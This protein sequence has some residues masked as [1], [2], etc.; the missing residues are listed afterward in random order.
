MILW[1]LAQAMKRRRDT[2]KLTTE[3]RERRNLARFRDL[4][5]FAQTTSPW[6]R[7]VIEQNHIDPL[8]CRPEHFPVLTAA[9][10]KDHFDEIVTDRAITRH[11]LESFIEQSR[12]PKDLYLGRYHVV[13]SS[14]SSGI[15]GTY[16]HTTDEIINGM[17]YGALHRNIKPRTRTT[18][19]GRLD[20]HDMGNAV[21]GLMDD[22]PQRLLFNTRNFDITAPWAQIIDGLNKHQPKIISAYKHYLMTLAE[23]A[24]AGR[25]RIQPSLLESGGEPLFPQEREILRSTFGCEIAN[26][27]G[28]T[29]INLMGVA[30]NDWEGIYLFEDDLIFEIGS[31]STCVTNLYNRTLPL[32]RYR[33]DDILM[34]IDVPNPRL[35][36]RAVSEKIGRSQEIIT[37]E[38]GVGDEHRFHTIWL[39]DGVDFTGVKR[40]QYEKKDF[41]TLSVRVAL[42]DQPELHKLCGMTSNN[43]K[44]EQLRRSFRQHLDD[45]GL[46]CVKLEISEVD[47]DQTQPEDRIVRDGRKER[48]VLPPSTQV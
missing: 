25:L 18:F 19:L 28:S 16:L 5:A 7:R 9:M 21:M 11:G 13:Q 48:L 43:E 2:L 6:Y 3:T 8:T 41:E 42:V 24:R 47:V 38:R 32:I 4:V 45:N 12:S 39:D 34:P 27:Y 20:D 17:S 14:G 46:S 10:V 31:E 26:S 37:F 30:L 1:K 29:E 36:F 40:V 33:F 22:W 35:P 15:P 23:E 44:I